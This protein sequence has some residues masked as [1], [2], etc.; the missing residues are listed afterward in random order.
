MYTKNDNTFYQWMQAQFDIETLKDI[1]NYGVDGGFNG[2]AYCSETTD[3]FNTHGDDIL[4]IIAEYQESLDNSFNI[5][6][7]NFT[8]TSLLFNH[9]VW[10]AAE[11]AASQI[12]KD[13]EIEEEME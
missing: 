4:K 11:I 1:V 12:L 7:S 9:I 2:L 10:H 8:N 3:L 13:M 6:L 5:Y